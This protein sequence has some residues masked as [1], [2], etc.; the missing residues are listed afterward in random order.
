MI[1]GT[2]DSAN[3]VSGSA[4]FARSSTRPASD[5]ARLPGNFR[6]I[7][8]SAVKDQLSSGLASSHVSP[9]VKVLAGMAGGVAEAVAL[10]PLDVTKTRL[11]L[12]KSGKY[13]G[14]VHCGRTIYA[15]EGAAALYKGLTPFITHLTLKYALRFGSFAWFKSIMGADKHGNASSGVNFA[16]GLAVGTTEA[17]A[18]VTP[19]EVVKTRLQK[20]RGT[21]NLRYTGPIHCVRT[22]VMEEGV[23]ALWNGALPTVLRQA[24]NQAFN[25][26]A[27]AWLNRVIWDKMDGDGKT[28][29]SWKTLVTGLVAGAMGPCAN[30][31]LDVVKTRMMGQE[32]KKGQEVKYKGFVH[33][34]TT[35]AKEEGVAALWKGLTPR[36]MR[37]APGQAITWTVVMKVQG[38]F[39]ARAI[40]AD[41]EQARVATLMGGSAP[42]VA[43][44]VKS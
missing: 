1:G 17:L 2:A 38:F 35:V 18:I 44:T 8:S 33:C 15:E 27:F 36:L 11:Q 10:Q 32:A 25:F 42:S 31:P 40:A 43:H 39:E 29:D 5:D 26:M 6:M 4:G 28:L 13:K 21:T 3:W 14:M 12:D 9:W 16:A 30:C 7:A 23:R 20:Q 41:L 34:I 19:F 22:I 24:T 37:L